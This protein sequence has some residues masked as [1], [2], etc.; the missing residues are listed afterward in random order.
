MPLPDPSGA[1]ECRRKGIDE[2]QI[3]AHDDNVLS[4]KVILK[5]GGVFIR[6]AHGKRFY[7]VD[8]RHNPPAAD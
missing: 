7:A 6:Q 1:G 5:N 8:L 3:S 4:N 2:L